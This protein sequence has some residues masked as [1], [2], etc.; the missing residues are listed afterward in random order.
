MVFIDAVMIACCLA[1]F[2]LWRSCLHRKSYEPPMNLLKQTDDAVLVG[3]SL[4]LARGPARP[5]EHLQALRHLLHRPSYNLVIKQA[6][7]IKPKDMHIRVKLRPCVCCRGRRCCFASAE[8]LEDHAGWNRCGGDDEREVYRERRTEDVCALW[9]WEQCGYL[10]G[11][12][13]EG[14]DGCAMRMVRTTRL[15]IPVHKLNL[16]VFL[17]FRVPSYTCHTRFVCFPAAYRWTGCD[18]YCLV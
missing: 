3:S 6:L 11:V 16:W 7:T 4:C 18:H 1:T 5:R 10:R 2:W 13:A 9:G 17:S 12:F 15:P 8:A 14:C